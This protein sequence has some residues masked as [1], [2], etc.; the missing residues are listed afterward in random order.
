MQTRPKY[1]ADLLSPYR[2][3]IWGSR[4]LSCTIICNG[5][6]ITLHKSSVNNMLGKYAKKNSWAVEEN[7]QISFEVS[8]L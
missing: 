1:K 6:V 2:S 7:F 8:L 5:A 4:A 3:I